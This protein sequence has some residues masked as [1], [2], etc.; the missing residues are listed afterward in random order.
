MTFKRRFKLSEQQGNEMWRRWKNSQR[1]AAGNV[2]GE[3]R[4]RP[5]WRATS[6]SSNGCRSASLGLGLATQAVSSC[7]AREADLN[8]GFCTR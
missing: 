3:S 8:G 6:V 7:H 1:I 2:D 4:G 5:P